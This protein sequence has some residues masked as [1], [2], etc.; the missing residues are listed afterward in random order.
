MDAMYYFL[1]QN[2]L[3]NFYLFGEVIHQD[4]DHKINYLHSFSLNRIDL[5][6]IYS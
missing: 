3:N 5:T 2:I 4:L 6:L 1:A